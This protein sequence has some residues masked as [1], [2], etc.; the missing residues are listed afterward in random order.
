LRTPE[1]YYLVT[2]TAFLCGTDQ[3]AGRIKAPMK[4]G[5]RLPVDHAER[6]NVMQ[7]DHQLLS[8]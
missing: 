5:A 2:D 3:I 8:F 7:H 4:D 1:G 6:E